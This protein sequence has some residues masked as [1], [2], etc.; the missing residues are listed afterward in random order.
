MSRGYVDERAEKRHLLFLESPQSV[1]DVAHVLG[2]QRD[3]GRV[4]S[5]QIHELQTGLEKHKFL[6]K[7]Y[8]V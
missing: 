8:K 7:I 5:P 2:G 1:A 6:R 3:Q 4:A